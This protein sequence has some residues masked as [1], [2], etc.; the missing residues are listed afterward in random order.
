MTVQPI[1]E[2]YTTPTPYLCVQGAAEAIEFY[3]KVF[4]A[5]EIMRIGSPDSRIGHAEIKIG[6]GIVMLSDEH[7]EMGV[8]GPKTIGGTPVS[9]LVYV[10][11]V[12]AKVKLAEELGSR[13]LSPVQDQFYGDRSGKIEDPFGHVWMISTHTEDVPPEELDRRVKEMYGG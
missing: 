1:P 2:G 11:D 10:Q 8:L 6:E 7:P 9:N 5:T 4:D 13:I 12:D 3:K